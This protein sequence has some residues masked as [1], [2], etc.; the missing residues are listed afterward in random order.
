MVE[1]SWKKKTRLGLEVPRFSKKRKKN[2]EGKGKEQ[3]QKDRGDGK[4]IF[5]KK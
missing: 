1:E 3:R 5:G 4:V 2:K